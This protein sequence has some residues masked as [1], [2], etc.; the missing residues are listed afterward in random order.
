MKRILF[1]SALALLVIN[2]PDARSDDDVTKL[3]GEHCAS[4]HSPDRLGA[5]GPALLPSN[6]SRLRREKAIDIIANGKIASQMPGFKDALTRSEIEALTE[7]IFS[8]PAETPVWPLEMIKSSRISHETTAQE[9]PAH[10]ANPMNLFVVVETGD[11][12]VTILDGDRMEPLTRFPS[13]FALHGGA[14][15]SPDGRFTFLASR[16]GWVMKYDLLK[17]EVVAEVRAGIN[18]RNIAV[19]PNGRFVVA[20]NYL[21]HNLV[22]LDATNLEPV[23]IINATGSNAKSSRVSAVYAAPPRNSLI[24]ALKDVPE[25]WELI[26]RSDQTSKEPFAIRRLLLEDYLDDFLFDQ[27]Y[28]TIIGASRGG[29][30]AK[31]ID[32]TNGNLI[33]DLPLEG[34]PHLGSGT[35]WDWSGRRIFATPHLKAA[36]IS[37][38]DMETWQPVQAIETAGPGFFTRS[39]KNSD[40]VWADVFFGPNKDQINVIDKKSLRIVKTLVPEPGKTS[41]HVEFTMDG[42]F[43]LVSILEDEG[44][45]IVFDAKTL[46]EVKRLP[47]RRP[48]GKYNVHNKIT[49]EEGT[50]H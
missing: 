2:T 36:Q 30:G 24:V 12:H 47:M 27:D 17:L 50:S 6:L 28:K 18:T 49:F 44:A 8:A 4:C 16:D 5:Q 35:S 34:M 43:A 13:R 20:G 25:V 41:G 10:S 31:V 21:P 26:E 29:K 39:H 46:E 38:F 23:Q 42:R 45:L 1:L 37:L 14:K 19:S 40:Y 11:H 15:F 48:V 33:S 3:Y 32:V 9:G 7:Y 22:V